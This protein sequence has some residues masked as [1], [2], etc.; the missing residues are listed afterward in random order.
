M[1]ESTI[2]EETVCE[3]NKEHE[4][5]I[6]REEL[7]KSF[8]YSGVSPIKLHG[9]TKSRQITTTKEKLQQVKYFHETQ[10]ARVIGVEVGKIREK[11]F[12]DEIRK[13][14]REK[15]A[16]LD[17]LHFLLKEKIAAST[18]REKIRLLTLVPDSWSRKQAAKFFNVTEYL[19][20]TAGRLKRE[21]GILAEPERKAGKSALVKAFYEDNEFSRMMPGKKTISV[22]EEVFTCKNVSSYAI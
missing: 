13:E 16:E 1:L 3:D 14:E 9:A 19:L 6:P 17:K 18:K 12:E 5:E 7:N 11:G 21:R 4:L 8:Q 10:A 15:T 20:R 2:T 22:W